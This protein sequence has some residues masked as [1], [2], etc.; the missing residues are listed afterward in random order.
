MADDEILDECDL[1]YCPRCGSDLQT[2]ELPVKCPTHGVVN[3]D[4]W[5]TNW[6]DN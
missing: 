4:Y 6:E 5:E 1:S 2:E 3:I